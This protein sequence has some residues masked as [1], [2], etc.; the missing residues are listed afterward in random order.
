MELNAFKRRWLKHFAPDISSKDINKYVVSTGNY[1]WH[2]FSWELLPSETYLEGDLARAAYNNANKDGAL[3]IEPFGKCA[4]KPL[5]PEFK[6]AS[7][8]DE[9][10]EIYVIANDYSWTYIKT[11]EN[12]LCGPYFIPKP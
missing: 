8:L 11:H 2:V 12:N 9:L 3:Y 7:K 6:D 10:T 1:I 5:T 4:C